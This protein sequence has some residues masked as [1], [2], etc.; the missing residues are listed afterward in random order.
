MTRTI[1]WRSRA[2][3]DGDAL[4]D[5]V[6]ELDNQSQTV[7]RAWQVD[8]DLLKSFLNDLGE[9]DARADSSLEISEVSPG[10][11][12]NLVIARAESGE[13]LTL[14]PQLYWEGVQYW[15]RSEG[16]DPHMWKDRRLR[17]PSS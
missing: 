14:D 9:L 13:V 6:V 7:T 4:N 17:T 11:W 5:A 8:A 10:N 1:E 16:Q 12:G 3:L 2:H 15:F